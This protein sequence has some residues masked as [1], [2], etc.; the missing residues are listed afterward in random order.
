MSS[1]YE[2]LL[3]SEFFGG[4]GTGDGGGGKREGTAIPYGQPVERI[5]FN[6]NNTQEETRAILSQL[7]FVQTPLMENPIYAVYANTED[8]NLGS[9]LFVSKSE[10]DPDH[11]EISEVKNIEKVDVLGYFWSGSSTIDNGWELQVA[12]SG[13]SAY[14]RIST[15]LEGVGVCNWGTT[16]TDF[17]G[18]PIGTENEKIKNVLSITPF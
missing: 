9:F 1:M 8:G 3:C 6:T 17:G 15:L 14:A 16:L 13:G 7:T 18:L 5:Y 12:L 4:G 2:K 11:Y 10:G